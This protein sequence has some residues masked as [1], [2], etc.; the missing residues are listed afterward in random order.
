MTKI[1]IYQ[2]IVLLLLSMIHTFS[3][4]NHGGDVKKDTI[5]KNDLTSWVSYNQYLMK[6]FNEYLST[7]N[8]NTI[9]NGYSFGLELGVISFKLSAKVKGVGGE[10]STL[11]LP[12]GL[13]YIN[14]RSKTKHDQ[15]NIVVDWNFPVF[16]VYIAPDILIPINKKIKLGIRPISFGYYFLG[17]GK[18]LEAG[19]TI[20][21]R[22]GNLKLTGGSIGFKPSIS[23]SILLIDNVF[24]LIRGGYRFLNFTT[25]NQKCEDGFTFQPGGG[26]I[27]STDFPYDLDFSGFVVFAGIT[28][29]L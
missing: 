5:K 3:F 29:Y 15:N 16:G 14:A 27:S 7:G 19:L 22:Q 18:T 4:A 8:N 11:K 25:V 28:I 13:E 1:I 2:G 17:F 20:S 24:V 12:L 23:G 9:N 26:S 10:S 21:D 6:D